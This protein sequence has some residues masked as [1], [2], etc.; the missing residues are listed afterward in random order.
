MESDEQV[1]E[2][3]KMQFKILQEQQQ[4]RMQNLLEKKKEKQQS[5]TQGH[6]DG[7]KDIFGVSDDLALST[8]DC[9]VAK[10]DFSKRLLEDEIEQLREQLRETVDENGRLYRLLK[11][12]DFE[13]KQL[14]KKI[15]EERLAMMGTGGLTGDVAASKI[16]QLAKQNRHLTA[17]AEKEKAKVKQLSHRIKELEKEL[18]L[19]AA[20]LQSHGG[21]DGRPVRQTADGPL[22]P[23]M[24]ALQD[25]LS[26][27]NL[28]VSECRNQL[29]TTKQEL[30]VAQKLLGSEVGEDV[31]V[32]NLMSNPGMWR[33]RAQQILVLQG[34]VR[35]LEC[36]L[37][38]AKNGTSLSCGDEDPTI[39]TSP[40]KRSAQRNL[41]RIQSLEREKKEALEKLTSEHSSL[42]KDHEEVKKKLDASKAR[43]QVLSSEVKTLKE[44]IATLLD[45]GKHDDELIDA[46][47]SQQKEM[48]V[49][50]KNLS[51]QEERNK[52][53]QQSLGKQ[54][55]VQEQKQNCVIEQLRQTLAEREAQVRAL[56]ENLISQVSHQQRLHRSEEGGSDSA[57]TLS[58]ESLE[59]EN[60]TSASRKGDRVGRNTSTRITSNMGHTLV[61][62]AETSIPATDSSGRPVE[63][64]DLEAKDWKVQIAEYKALCLAAELERDKLVQLVG[65]LQKRV[66][67]SSA[68]VWAAEK[69]LQEQ[70]RKSIA[71]EQQLEKLRAEAGKNSVVSKAPFKGKAGQSNSST[72]LSWSASEKKD[73]PSAELTEVPL[74]SQ[75]EDLSARLT[76]Q[77]D[78]NA[79]LKT[80]LE[81][82]MKIKEEDFRAYQET[83]GQVKEIFL[84]ALR[85]Q[86]Q[87]RS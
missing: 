83:M 87:E 39:L 25:K 29:Q 32:Q 48:Q 1:N 30:R 64:N 19:S 84:Q 54:L 40:G 2:H 42:Q 61:E 62:S 46:L 12:R 68:R 26:A 38:H 67:D 24:K 55:N 16:V 63:T 59:E 11:E 74:E 4:K 37:G 56:E 17:E 81:N 13:I 43:S 80:A 20:M 49:I 66:D 76:V 18:H 34:K 14:Q 77:M 15:E 45:K 35:E 22:S 9:P 79:G 41:Q 23:E 75:I 70:Q 31:N 36:Q 50:L 10:E 3:L 5:L 33:G 82:L 7:Q 57:S 27:A 44:Q 72:R 86:K 8:L 71:L 52:E 47:M 65:V 6:P 21:K 53:C 78:E 69:Q 85:Q 58:A 51:Q 28:K 60:C 73:P